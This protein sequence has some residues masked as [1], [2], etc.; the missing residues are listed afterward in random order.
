MKYKV[1]NT[2][3]EKQHKNTKYEKGSTYPKS[4]F[5]SDPD[6]VAF[7]QTDKNQYNMAFIGEEIKETKRS[8]RMIIKDE[9]E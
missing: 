7:L 1:I 3:I 8:T 4:G 5:K 6:R 2:F 9:K